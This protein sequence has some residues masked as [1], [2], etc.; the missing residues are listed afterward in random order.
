MIISMHLKCLTIKIYK[1]LS[2]VAATVK[3]YFPDPLFNF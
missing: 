2:K 1:V 3:L